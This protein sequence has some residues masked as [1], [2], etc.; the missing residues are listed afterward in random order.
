MQK[1]C[2]Y[3]GKKFETKKGHKNQMYCCKSC[4]VKD[5]YIEDIGIFRDEVDDCIKKYILGLIITDGCLSK[6]GSRIF[7]CIS[8]KDFE[9]IERIRNLVCPNKKIYKDGNN[10]QVRK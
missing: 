6:S 8:L 1:N 7:I 3:C 2:K 5:K 9:M 4:S 10:Y